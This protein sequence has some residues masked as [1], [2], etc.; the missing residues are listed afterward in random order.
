VQLDVICDPELWLTKVDP[1]QLESALLN[2]SINARDAMLPGG[3]SLTITT[4]NRAIEGAAAAAAELTPGSYVVLSVTDSGNGMTPDVVA[5]AFDPFFTTKPIGAGTGLGLSMVY[6]FVRQSGGQVAVRSQPDAGTTMTLYFPR[7]TGDVPLAVETP[8]ADPAQIPAG[9]CILVVEDEAPLRELFA[10]QLSEFGYDVIAV[11]DGAQAVDILR[12]DRRI[13][14]LLTDVGLPGG[15]NGR[16]VA[17]AGQSA[18][19]DLKVLF[20][21]GYAQNAADG[22]GSLGRGMKVLTKPFDIDTLASK[23]SNMLGK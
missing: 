15:L 1:P 3:G 13:D 6:G 19:P 21:T 22:D 12:S 7:H 10:E 8:P 5:R 2:L 14:L 16:Q 17:D 9:E 11:E 4:E 23:V 18:R 20:I